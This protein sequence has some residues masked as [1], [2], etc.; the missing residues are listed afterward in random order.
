M[1]WLVL[2]LV[3]A[4]LALAG[5]IGLIVPGTRGLHDAR[6]LEMNAEK[7]KR[8]PLAAGAPVIDAGAC[9]EWGP[10]AASEVARAQEE[11]AKFVGV[12][13]AVVDAPDTTVWWVHL[14][15]A[16]SREEAERRVKDLEELGVKD[17]RVVVDETYRHA[18]SLGI[19]RSQA[20]ATAYQTRLRESK[21]RNTAVVQRADL[22]RFS[23]LVI[24]AP[25]PA[26]TA[27]VVELKPAF[28]GSEVRAAPCPAAGG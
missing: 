22:V 13:A 23:N 3:C 19:F 12:R 27:R 20:A 17:A 9:L 8:V 26:L 2:L 28:A 4:N 16:R 18:V 14:P 25:P 10:L 15:P 7:V 21:V 5:Y 11:V 24:A 1:R 6:S